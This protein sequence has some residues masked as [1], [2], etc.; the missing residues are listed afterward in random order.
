MIFKKILFVLFFFSLT[1]FILAKEKISFNH[2]L[3]AKE[4]IINKSKIQFRDSLKILALRVEFQTDDDSKT[5]GTGNFDLTKNLQKIIDPPPHDAVY[6]SNHLEFAKNYFARS[7][8]NKLKITSEVFPSVVMLSK[9]MQ[10][11]S[12]SQ[13]KIGLSEMIIEAWQKADS[14]SPQFNFKN[15][16]MFVIFHAGVGLDIDLVSLYGYNPTPLD[17]P[18]IYFSHSSF[19]NIYGN[20]FNGII[21]KNQPDFKITNS[22]ILPETES[23]E[24]ASFGGTFLLQLS[25]NGI[26]TSS[27]ASHL[28]LPDLFD[29]KT[30]RS[31]IGRFG[32]M[33]GQAMF[34]LSGI[35]PPEPSA[36]EKYFLGWINPISIFKTDTTISISSVG[37]SLVEDSVIKIPI[38]SKEYFLL[39][40]RNRDPENDGVIVTIRNGIIEE[41]K[42]FLYDSLNG[43]NSIVDSLYGVI[44]DIDNLDWSLPGYIS[45]SY[46][47]SGGILIWHIDENIIN[48]NI[49]SNTI[50]NDKF[51]R[52]VDVEEADGSQ[53]IGETYGFIS[54]GLGSEEGTPY[55]FWFD[56]NIAPQFKNIF[57]NNSTPNSLSNSFGKTNITLKDF[58][59]SGSKMSFKIESFENSINLAKIIKHKNITASKNNQPTTV[60]LNNDGKSEL[61]YSSGDSI[62]VLDENLNS[63]SQSFSIL[64]I[65]SEFHPSFVNNFCTRIPRTIKDIIASKDSNIFLIRTENNLSV[66]VN[67]IPIPKKIIGSS[68]IFNSDIIIPTNEGIYRIDCWADAP[69]VTKINNFVATKIANIDGSLIVVLQNEIVFENAKY[70]ISNKN[71]SD[72]SF[73]KIIEND[74]TELIGVFVFEDG[75]IL[76]RSI[77]ENPKYN[78]SPNVKSVSSGI[79]FADCDSDGD[80]DIL[81]AD[82]D[83]LFS[84]NKQGVSISNFPFQTKD[85]G[86]IIGT[87]LVIENNNSEQI[88]LFGSSNGHL[89]AIGQNGKM[90]SGFPLQATSISSSPFI[91]G[92]KLGVA[93]IDSTIHIWDLSSTFK[94]FKI[95]WNGILGDE[96]NSNYFSQSKQKTFR[97]QNLLPKEYAYN[98]PNPVYDG[99]TQI[100]YYLR[101]NSEVKIKILSPNGEILEELRGTGYGGTD[102]EIIWDATKYQTGV[103]IAKIE[104]NSSSKSETAIIKIAIVK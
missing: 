49:S 82:G 35:S 33:D 101:E 55:D 57:S 31:A 62:F 66:S 61:I 39:E 104:A 19:K 79:A 89:Y 69:N 16:D 72:A 67:K 100:R 21:L 26:L 76:I 41:K 1:N 56:G 95:I 85:D 38:N 36:W 15:Y 6:F 17:L 80:A 65:G 24:L 50:N 77:A 47:L 44:V 68:L 4:L 92:N 37:G 59:K 90:I 43:T 34:S 18:S 70:F 2:S 42:R 63:F 7:S 12:P 71:I 96:K 99:K 74:K 40:N 28:G 13:N 20:D 8:N 46:N 83:K 25:I 11:Y 9:N 103:Y 97:T 73:F 58:S 64:N 75:K 84:F 3:R 88:I 45:K 10:S 22:A 51:N 27:I 14:I 93:T 94:D 87:P 48:K 30:G 91:F 53:D 102:N 78:F 81:I 32:L 54:A 29:T 98:W 52:G 60:D 5:T 23:R 86:N